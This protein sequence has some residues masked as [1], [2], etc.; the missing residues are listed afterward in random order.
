MLL[1]S[2]MS[3]MPVSAAALA[4]SLYSC[5]VRRESMR[6][7]PTPPKHVMNPNAASACNTALQLHRQLTRNSLVR[8]LMDR[9]QRL[10]HCAGR[11]HRLLQCVRC[12]FCL[13]QCGCGNLRASQAGAAGNSI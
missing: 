1:S 2:G 7:V 5:H 12:S 10:L 6:L 8:A 13:R 3:W 11:R 9:W 4:A